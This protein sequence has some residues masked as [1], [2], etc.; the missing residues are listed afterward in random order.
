MRDIRFRVWDKKIKKM[1]YPSFD[2]CFEFHDGYWVVTEC[3]PTGWETIVD[4]ESGVLMQF[5]GLIDKQGKEIYE[6]D[7]LKHQCRLVN[8]GK[9]GSYYKTV[10]WKEGKK[11]GVGFNVGVSYKDFWEVIG[12]I[13]EN[14]EL[15]EANDE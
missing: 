7:V 1:I 12:N 15:A 13:Y 2:C 11:K 6:G 10:K 5:T 3:K 14:P 4:E 9:N 8:S